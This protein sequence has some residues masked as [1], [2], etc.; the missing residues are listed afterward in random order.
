MKYVFFIH[1]VQEVSTGKVVGLVFTSIFM[2]ISLYMWYW[3]WNGALSDEERRLSQ[4]EAPGK[5]EESR[6][7]GSQP[8]ASSSRHSYLPSTEVSKRNS[9]LTYQDSQPHSESN[10]PAHPRNPT[11]PSPL[12]PIVA[13]LECYLQFLLDGMILL[14]ENP[15]IWASMSS[16]LFV[17][18]YFV[19][20]TEFLILKNNSDSSDRDWGFGQV[21]FLPPLQEQAAERTADICL[22]G[23][24]GSVLHGAGAEDDPGNRTGFGG[25]IESSVIRPKV[26]A[27]GLVINHGV[28]LLPGWQQAQTP[29]HNVYITLRTLQRF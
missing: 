12:S 25:S 11:T 23:C 28:V 1:G 5:Q 17:F 9:A 24:C 20:S 29:F 10:S 16:Q 7:E 26:Y 8:M 22:Y 4:A 27:V 2:A 13:I 21:C 3:M 18:I 19:V 15:D 6:P 14:V